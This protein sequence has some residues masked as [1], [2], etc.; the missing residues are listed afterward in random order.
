VRAVTPVYGKGGMAKGIVTKQFAK[1]ATEAGLRV[2][3]STEP[4]DVL[5]G[6]DWFRFLGSCK[7]T[8]VSRGGATARDPRGEVRERVNRYLQEHPDA[9]YEEVERACFPGEDRYDFSAISPRIFEAAT[10]RTGLVMMEADYLPGMEPY[11][12]YIPVKADFSNLDEVFA[13]MRDDAG[14]ER[15]IESAYYFLIAG[16]RFSYAA[17]VGDVLGAVAERRPRPRPAT[18]ADYA[19]LARHFDFLAPIQHM[20]FVASPHWSQVARLTFARARQTGRVDA[21]ANL[22]TCGERP[23][24]ID[25]LGLLSAGALDNE[26]L[27]VAAEAMAG[28]CGEPE[29]RK[30]VEAWIKGTQEQRWP[31]EFLANAGRCEYVFEPAEAAE[32]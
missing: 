20:D 11:R 28:L 15:M 24:G 5:L 7:F 30:Q 31:F 2:D 23:R 16:G 17:F 22:L 27:A 3:I 12:H 32:Q 4:A 25:A 21:L 9:S 13:L 1:A 8:F 18:A 19:G 26:V 6:S 14:A 29:E 10:L